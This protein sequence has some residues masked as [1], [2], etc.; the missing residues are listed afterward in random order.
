MSRE[1]QGPPDKGWISCY[2][3]H[4]IERMH[5]F[6]QVMVIL[7]VLVPLQGII[8]RF[9]GLA[10]VQLF[11]YTQAAFCRV[12][13]S[14]LFVKTAYPTGSWVIRPMPA[15]AVMD[16]VNKLQC[17]ITE[18]FVFGQ[19]EKRDKVAHRKR[20][21]PQVAALGPC[22]SKAGQTG[23]VLHK[24]HHNCIGSISIHSSSKGGLT[25]ASIMKRV[26]IFFKQTCRHILP[27][28]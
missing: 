23:K 22:R 5:P 12:K 16:L 17:K 27:L 28:I 26:F 4:A 13:L 24:F 8:R 25:S 7:P 21:R 10:F 2:P 20:I 19:A 1:F 11:S 18:S 14:L 3:A 9:A 6:R 15:K